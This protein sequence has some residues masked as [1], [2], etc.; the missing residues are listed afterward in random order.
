M[1]SIT[2][3]CTSHS[4]SNS[5]KQADR[6]LARVVDTKTTKRHKPEAEILLRKQ[7]LSIPQVGGGTY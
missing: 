1:V 5:K 6:Q 2:I 7:L 4:Q 3:Y